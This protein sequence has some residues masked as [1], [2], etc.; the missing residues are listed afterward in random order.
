MCRRVPS[1]LR[2]VQAAL[3]ATPINSTSLR[4][5]T[6]LLHGFIA[7]FSHA[8]A[9]CGSHSRNCVMGESQGPD[10]AFALVFTGCAF[11]KLR[12]GFW[13]RR[14]SRHFDEVSHH[15]LLSRYLRTKSAI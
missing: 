7:I 13:R 8:S 10:A 5:S 15:Y 12:L 1:G 6:P 4:D 11:K 2:F 9:H 3:S 14:S